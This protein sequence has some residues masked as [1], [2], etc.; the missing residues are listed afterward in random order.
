M[1]VREWGAEDGRPLVFWHALGAITSGAG[2]TELAPTLTAAG[3]R[4]I[5]PDA[6]G[7]GQSPPLP[8]ERYEVDS[9]LGLL[10]GVLDERGLERA[11][12]MGHS[13]GGTVVTAFAAKK[14]DRVEGLLL[15]D[16]GHMDYQD[17]P[18]FPHGKSRD[19]LIQDAQAAGELRV[20]K[21]GLAQALQEGAGVRRAVTPELVEAVKA[22]FREEDGD[23]VNI[24]N[25][26]VR[27]AALYGV[28]QVRVKD[29]WPA[30][31]EAGIP[32]LLLLATEPEETRRQ[33]EQAV[34]VFEER[35]PDAEIHWIEGAGHD[36]FADA[37]PEV[38]RLVRDWASRTYTQMRRRSAS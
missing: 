34:P 29:S 16:S 24:T 28:T 8:P 31:A 9:L 38:A 10:E 4:L 3:L 18:N 26:E 2:L 1:H 22:G 23:L 17:S 13:W 37:G 21:E 19:D 30:I 33:N 14:P 32:I 7:F 20:P 15:I 5:A 27:G 6:P 25:P 12:L 36:L 11:I 35:F